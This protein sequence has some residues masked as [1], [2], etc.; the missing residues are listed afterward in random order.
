MTQPPFPDASDASGDAHDPSPLLGRWRLMRADSVLDFAPDVQME[1][2]RGGR[3]LY[4]FAVG[5]RREIITL[6]Y[7]VEGDTLHTDNPLTT[8]EMSTHFV[9]GAGG[10]LIFDF[11]GAHAWFVREL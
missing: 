1:F 2:Q 7:R 10:V 3:L 8:H 4:G 6:I 11:A 9:I 5:D